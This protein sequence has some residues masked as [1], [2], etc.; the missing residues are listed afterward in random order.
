[1]VSSLDLVAVA[2]TLSALVVA[3]AAA[4]AALA[5]DL[6]LVVVAV[7]PTDLM[8]VEQDMVLKEDNLLSNLLVLV[9]LLV[10][11]VLVVQVTVE[12]IPQVTLK[13]VALVVSHLLLL[14]L[15]PHK[16]LVVVAV[17]QAL[18]FTSNLKPVV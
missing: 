1:M 8:H 13:L 4:V 18:P 14:I 9:Q 17:D 11:Q 3:E 5:Q 6:V 16:V 12:T 7:D 2:V 15:S 10:A